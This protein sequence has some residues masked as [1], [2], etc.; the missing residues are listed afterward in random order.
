MTAFIEQVHDH[1]KRAKCDQCEYS[2]VTKA[3]LKEHSNGVHLKI[4]TETTYKCQTCNYVTYKNGNIKQH[5][6]SVH[7][8]KNDL[9]DRNA[10]FPHLI[11]H[12]LKHTYR[13]CIR[14]R[15]VCPGLCLYCPLLR[16]G[17]IKQLKV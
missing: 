6:I 2:A 16:R 14:K 11:R 17:S 4:R 3:G 5:T 10:N 15:R 9:Y 12:T 13:P 1:I 8:N 7:D